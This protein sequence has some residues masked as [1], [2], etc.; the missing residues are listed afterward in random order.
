MKN[1]FSTLFVMCITFSPAVLHAQLVV[2]DPTMAGLTAANKATIVKQLEESARQTV[3]LKQTYDQLKKAGEVYTKVSNGLRNAE[4]VQ[5]IL[6]KQAQLVIDCGACIGKAAKLKA[7]STKNLTILKNNIN[8]VV[9][10]NRVTINLINKLLNEG[11]FKMNDGERLALIMDAERKT[12]EAMKKV[13]SYETGYAAA[14]NMINFVK[15]NL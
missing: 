8:K 4:M 9:E 12:D 11:I 5:S 2:S 7:G 3:Q 6:A 13:K 15:K 1:V 10:G 14:N